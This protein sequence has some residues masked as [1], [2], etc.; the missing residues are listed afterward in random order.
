MKSQNSS[1]IC[2]AT[3]HDF[4][5]LFFKK[6]KIIYLK[7]KENCIL[8]SFKFKKNIVT[9]LTYHGYLGNWSPTEKSPFSDNFIY[10]PS[11]HHPS[12][13]SV[14]GTAAASGW[15]PTCELIEFCE[16]LINHEF[17][18]GSSYQSWSGVNQTLSVS[19]FFLVNF[20]L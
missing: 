8:F 17:N 5:F 19:V 9:E 20:V 4:F 6:N 18:Y 14:V 12:W 7:K 3:S 15:P 1:H 10:H 13:C 2:V 16:L 11:I